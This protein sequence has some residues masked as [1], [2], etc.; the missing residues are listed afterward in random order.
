MI[1]K[2]INTF[3][4]WLSIITSVEITSK[5]IYHRDKPERPCIANFVMAY[6]PWITAG[7]ITVAVLCSINMVSNIFM[8]PFLQS[9]K[10]LRYT[11][12]WT[13]LHKLSWAESLALM[14]SLFMALTWS[15][16]N[17]CAW[18]DGTVCEQPT[19][20]CHCP[21]SFSVDPLAWSS[22]TEHEFASACVQIWTS[23][24]SI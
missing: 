11:H 7:F 20:V 3:H 23:V 22:F 15:E 16:L 21:Q 8:Q 5:M 14:M 1:F 10:L 13:K 24:C 12:T 6:K 2:L 9:R 17:Y 4:C 18:F 19:L